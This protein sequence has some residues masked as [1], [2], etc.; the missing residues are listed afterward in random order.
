MLR[1]SGGVGTLLV[2]ERRVGL[3]LTGDD[4]LT[5]GDVG[6]GSSD[7]KGTGVL[8]GTELAAVRAG[9]GRPLLISASLFFCDAFIPTDAGGAG[10]S[11]AGSAA[12]TGCPE[13][14]PSS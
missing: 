7:S 2:G 9:A 4:A 6:S 1:T 3:T 14:G 8:E 5:A 10:I 13:A 12:M 11:E